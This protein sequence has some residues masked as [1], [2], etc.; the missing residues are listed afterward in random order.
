MVLGSTQTPPTAIVSTRRG[1]AWGLAPPTEDSSVLVLTS[2]ERHYVDIRFALEGPSTAGPFWAFAGRVSYTALVGPGQAGATATS[3]GIGMR[4]EWN[5]P[6][7][8]YGNSE[9]VDK[10]D[11]FNLANGDQIEVGLLE[12]PETGKEDR[13]ME[14]WTKPD[15]YDAAAQGSTTPCVVAKLEKDGQLVGLA[16][17]V[18]GFAQ[19]IRLVEGGGVMVARWTKQSEWVRDDRGNEEKHSVPMEWLVDEQRQLSDETVN[20][21]EKWVVVERAA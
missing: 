21:S 12:N 18:G 8:S 2:P 5:H 3:W 17:R 11:L 10:A 20:E 9:G 14:Y 13:F 4:G 1:I 15:G 16:I 7:D 6:I 19:G